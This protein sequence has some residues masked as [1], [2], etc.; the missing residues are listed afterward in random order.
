[1]VDVSGTAF[2]EILDRT[3]ADALAVPVSGDFANLVCRVGTVF[4]DE[5][6]ASLG[7]LSL[8]GRVCP[9]LAKR[10]FASARSRTPLAVSEVAHNIPLPIPH[11][12]DYDWRFTEETVDRLLER[13]AG[14]GGPLVALGAPSVFRRSVE[15]EI[16][17]SVRLVDANARLAAAFPEHTRSGIV[18]CDVRADPLPGISARTA[19]SDPPWYPFD[20]RAFLWAARAMIDSDGEILLSLAPLTTRP[21]IPTERE[22]LLAWAAAAGLRRTEEHPGALLYRTPPFEQAALRANGI[23][24]PA[25]PWRRGDLWVFTV[26]GPLRVD[27]PLTPRVTDWLEVTW[28]GV[29]V[30]FRHALVDSARQVDPRLVP[31]IDGDVLP[32]VSRRHQLRS[33]VAV[34]TS[35]NR[36]FGCQD[37]MLL[38]AAADAG[39]R[40]NDPIPA[41]EEYLRRQLSRRERANVTDAM[42][43][44]SDIIHIERTEYA[45]AYDR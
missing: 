33:R 12:L 34:W 42:N 29:R 35:G 1:M 39:A 11:P 7:R 41:A 28:S 4:P 27:R 8:A 22:E 36:V 10:I 9:E 44:L 31:L 21:G 5:I 45:D 18:C 26:E 15:L 24:C 17:S 30:R 37:P 16:H 20:T 3:V 2:Q 32:S 25:S 23:C 13:S 14:S 40:C 6:L 43:R 38:H 19:V